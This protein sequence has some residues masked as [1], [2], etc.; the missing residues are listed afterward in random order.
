MV[1]L[2]ERFKKSKPPVA[3]GSPQKEI[4]NPEFMAK[5]QHRTPPVLR[6]FSYPTNITYS[7]PSPSTFSV[8]REPPSSWDQLGEICNFSS[9]V[10]SQARRAKTVGL[11]DP[12]FYSTDRTPHQRLVNGDGL[13]IPNPKTRQSIDS[14]FISQRPAAEK[15]HRRSTLLGLSTSQV[16]SNSRL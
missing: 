16:P 3:L 7:N 1:G 9:G 8:Q 4:V 6:N 2:V 13:S 10:S 11:E 15:R 12:F 14:V 5:P